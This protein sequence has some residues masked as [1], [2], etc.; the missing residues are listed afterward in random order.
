MRMAISL[1]EESSALSVL[2]PEGPVALGPRD[3]PAQQE[4]D[5]YMLNESLEF[6]RRRIPGKLHYLGLNSVIPSYNEYLILLCS[7]KD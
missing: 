2:T 3:C 5:N 4:P 1:K 7:R 6:L